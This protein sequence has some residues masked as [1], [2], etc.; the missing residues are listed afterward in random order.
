MSN[1]LRQ[2]YHLLLFW[3]AAGL[4]VLSC[5]WSIQSWRIPRHRMS[6]TGAAI[7][8]GARH[9]AAEYPAEET[10]P[11][12]WAESSNPSLRDDQSGEIFGAPPLYFDES[13]KIYRL[14]GR[15]H[16]VPETTEAIE[17]VAIVPEP[18]QLQLTGYVGTPGNYRAILTHRGGDSTWV[19]REGESS[20]LLGLTLKRITVVK[21]PVS[22][23]DR[24]PVQE[25]AARAVLFV[26][27]TGEEVQLD[28]RST[29][30]TG[31]LRNNAGPA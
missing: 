25:I 7:L 12:L 31:T 16:R 26:R 23:G 14:A 8:I 19:A 27:K 5:G 6:V 10:A 15:A 3:L 1:W 4:L 13:R 28:S 17:L 29:K 11:A 30:Y 20:D 9:A 24:W 22:H 21:I 2:R 18:F